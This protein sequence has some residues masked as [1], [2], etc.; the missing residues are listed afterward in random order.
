MPEGHLERVVRV[1][2][3][4]KIDDVFGAGSSCGSP[5]AK[6][7]KTVFCYCAP[8]FYDFYRSCPIE[9]SILVSLALDRLFGKY[10]V[11]PIQFNVLRHQAFITQRDFAA[12]TF[13]AVFCKC[14]YDLVLIRG[15]LYVGRDENGVVVQLKFERIRSGPYRYQSG[16]RNVYGVV[17]L[18][19]A[20]SHRQGTQCRQRQLKQCLFHNFFVFTEFHQLNPDEE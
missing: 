17:I 12:R 5:Y 9:F 2:T 16:R 13:F 19:Q 6:G 10:A 4:D 18:V 20:R 8:V 11:K 7:E 14:A 15:C 1:G 3:C